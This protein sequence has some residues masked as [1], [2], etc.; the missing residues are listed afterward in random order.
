MEYLILR[1]SGDIF[2]EITQKFLPGTVSNQLEIRGKA[3]LGLPH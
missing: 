1:Q 2:P 3:F